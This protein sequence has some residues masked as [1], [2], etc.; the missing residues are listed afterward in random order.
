MLVKNVL[1]S[2]AIAWWVGGRLWEVLGAPPFPTWGI[3]VRL[4]DEW[5]LAFKTIYVA[6][7]LLLV[8]FGLLWLGEGKRLRSEIRFIKETFSSGR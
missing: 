3:L 5:D 7:P 1:I 6:I 4:T 8:Y 2:A